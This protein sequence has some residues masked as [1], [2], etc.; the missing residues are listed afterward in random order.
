MKPYCIV[1]DILEPRLQI[2]GSWTTVVHALFTWEPETYCIIIYKTYMTF[3]GKNNTWI[4]I[5]LR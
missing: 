2:G 4:R 3:S 1:S 5:R